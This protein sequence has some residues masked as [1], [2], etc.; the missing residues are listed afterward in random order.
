MIFDNR[1]QFLGGI[2][3]GVGDLPPSE[4]D[5]HK[6]GNRM[7]KGKVLGNDGSGSRQGRR[8]LNFQARVRRV[9]GSLT[10]S[11]GILAI[12]NVETIWQEYHHSDYQET[13]TVLK[14]QRKVSHLTLSAATTADFKPLQSNLSRSLEQ[15]ELKDEN[16]FTHL[17]TL[18]PLQQIMFRGVAH[19]KRETFRSPDYQEE[20][21]YDL[22]AYEI[23]HT[24]GS[25]SSI[26]AYLEKLDSTEARGVGMPDER[27]PF[28]VFVVANGESVSSSI[29]RG[30][31]LINQTDISPGEA[32]A[33]ISHRLS[34]GVPF[35]S[36]SR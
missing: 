12:A 35:L 9:A 27:V 1:P 22:V 2:N 6:E 19:F 24:D 29:F 23:E 11:A 10:L 18:D 20:S 5:A 17:S 26:L 14:N 21:G 16:P 31:A 8:A 15:D 7:F 36:V 4:L 28:V 32:E 25:K 33:M 30:G 34:L 3:N 13:R